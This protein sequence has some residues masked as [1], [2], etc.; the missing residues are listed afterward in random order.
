MWTGRGLS[1]TGGDKGGRFCGM[2]Q[3]IKIER[4]I[5]L[6]EHSPNGYGKYPFDELKVGESF[7]MD[8]MKR[9]GLSSMWN[10]H[11]PKKF[12]SRAV[13]ETEVRVWRIE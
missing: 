12:I 13:S 9:A 2:K 5:P 7:L 3:Q 6:P 11:K 8:K 1:L 10:R 4:G